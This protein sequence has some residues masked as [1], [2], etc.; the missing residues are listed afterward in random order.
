MLGLVLFGLGIEA[1]CGVDILRLGQQ[2]P[3]IQGC[4]R[5]AHVCVC[6]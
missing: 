6:T 2:N 1:S 4:V 3:V 5:R